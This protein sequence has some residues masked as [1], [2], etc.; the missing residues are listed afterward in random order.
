MNGAAGV[1]IYSVPINVAQLDSYSIQSYFGGSPQVTA[2]LEI[3]NQ[4]S[5]NFD[6]NKNQRTADLEI[7][8]WEP[9][10]GAQG[11]RGN[12]LISSSSIESWF[13]PTPTHR[14]VRMK[15]VKGALSVTT[16]S[17][18]VQGRGAGS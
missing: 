16:M 8:M 17:G 11:G 13:V 12:V 14:Y 9:L 7:K 2:S 4:K 15:I 10:P 3:S 6:N 1:T 18:S 5:E